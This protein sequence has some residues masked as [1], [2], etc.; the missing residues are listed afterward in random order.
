MLHHHHVVEKPHL[1]QISHLVP[2]QQEEAWPLPLPRPQPQP[3]H[4]HW[5]K[6]GYTNILKKELPTL[7]TVSVLVWFLLL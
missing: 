1:P 6:D 2:T 3:Q 4:Q 7:L 5:K